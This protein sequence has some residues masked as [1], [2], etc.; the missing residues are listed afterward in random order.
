MKTTRTSRILAA[1]VAIFS[2][3]FMQLA[4]ASYA[5]PGVALPGQAGASMVNM[6][7][8]MP[9]CEGMD[10]EQSTLCHV[11]V[12]GEP[13]KQ[14][15]AKSPVPDIQPFVP[16]VLVAVL[17]FADVAALPTAAPFVPIT[18]ARSTAPPIAIRNCCFR[19]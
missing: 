2:L 9:D 12:H 17:P 5:C 19:F 13:S 3:L 16:L 8:D 10:K 6:A 1:I 18:L 7:L 14:S 15:L 4:V 11:Y